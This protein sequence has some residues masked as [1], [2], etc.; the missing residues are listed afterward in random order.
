MVAI[1]LKRYRQTLS[2]ANRTR[3]G[4]Y[5]KIIFFITAEGREIIFVVNFELSAPFC[6]MPE[7]IIWSA[8]NFS[9]EVPILAPDKLKILLLSSSTGKAEIENF[10]KVRA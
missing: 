2:N 3:C 1:L 7:S 5:D 10:L 4:V 8:E 6:A 9:F